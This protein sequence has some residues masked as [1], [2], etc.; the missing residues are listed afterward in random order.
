MSGGAPPRLGGGTLL[1][2]PPEALAPRRR[3]ILQA[4][5]ATGGASVADLAG[6]FGVTPQT[7]RRDLRVLEALN[8]VRKGFGGA[9]A[10]PGAAH[11]P[12][13]ERRRVQT[14]VKRRLMAALAPFLGDHATIFVGLGAAFA[15]FH[16][17][18]AQRTG[19]FVATPDLEVAHSC[20]LRGA[21]SVYVY[22]GYVRDRDSAILTLARERPRK[23]KFD[24]AVIGASAID[25][26]GAVL[27]FDPLE[28]D[29]TQEAL[30]SA[31]RVALVAPLEAFG[32]HAP[33][34]VTRLAEID[35]LIGEPG[36]RKGLNPEAIPPDL[37]IV[38][39][40]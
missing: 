15:A 37:R 36:L 29:L 12:H 38:E 10:A 13:G 40:A 35:V 3:E 5:R 9:F 27:E 28:V 39:A 26:D 33:H 34:L 14:P 19:L 21:A 7:V 1:E 23:F 16:E 30:A 32:R 20:A 18:A 11:P 25:R 31:R 22:G 24:L 6:R 4:L 2:E 17:A 8:L